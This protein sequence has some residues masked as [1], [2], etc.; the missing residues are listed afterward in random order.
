MA[1]PYIQQQNGRVYQMSKFI[2]IATTIA[3]FSVLVLFIKWAGQAVLA[4]SALIAL[5]PV[6][7]VLVAV[8]VYVR[9]SEKQK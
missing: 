7:I 1:T 2:K 5:I 3:S 4:G 6:S 8:M 9:V